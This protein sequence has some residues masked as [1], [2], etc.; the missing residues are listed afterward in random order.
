MCSSEVPLCIFRKFLRRRQP[1]YFYGP[2]R[3]CFMLEC[4][5]EKEQEKRRRR[6]VRTGSQSAMMQAS[7]GLESSHR[8]EK[9]TSSLCAQCPHTHSTMCFAPPEY[10]PPQSGWTQM[11]GHEKSVSAT[12]GENRTVCGGRSG[13]ESQGMRWRKWGPTGDRLQSRLWAGDATP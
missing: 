6:A 2:S 11:R 7:V 8:A 10:E 3:H 1:K 9:A 12:V 4:W 5:K 13:G